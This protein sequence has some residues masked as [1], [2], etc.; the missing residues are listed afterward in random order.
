MQHRA[1]LNRHGNVSLITYANL[2]PNSRT[3]PMSMLV[4]DKI[5]FNANKK[6]VCIS[7]GIQTF[8][9]NYF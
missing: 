5:P 8:F 3:C 4:I 7:N 2:P 1:M 9:C 6:N